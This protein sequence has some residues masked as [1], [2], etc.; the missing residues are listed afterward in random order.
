MEKLLFSQCDANEIRGKWKLE[1]DGRQLVLTE[2]KA[3]SQA[4]K[5]KVTLDIYKTGGIVVRIGEPQYVFS[6]GN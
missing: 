1:K 6:V 2:I 5:K 3:G 4:G